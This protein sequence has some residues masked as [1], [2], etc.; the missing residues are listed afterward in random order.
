MVPQERNRILRKGAYWEMLGQSMC[1][2]GGDNGTHYPFL[3]ICDPWSMKEVVW[4]CHVH[5]LCGIPLCMLCM[6]FVTI[7]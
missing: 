2:I 5:L 4:L 7:G 6:C 1:A 3:G